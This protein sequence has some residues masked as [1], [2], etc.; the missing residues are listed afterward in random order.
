VRKSTLFLLHSVSH[1]LLVLF[2]CARLR[3]SGSLLL[4]KGTQAR[5]QSKG[6]TAAR[7][8]CH[9]FKLQM[10]R[11][12]KSKISS[13][14]GERAPPICMR[15]FNAC[16]IDFISARSTLSLLSLS[17]FTSGTRIILKTP[18]VRDFHKLLPFPKRGLQ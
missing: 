3:Q 9:F 1:S 13:S 7:F 17:C 10:C 4:L 18:D 11:C 14:F 16:V 6:F 5:V 12:G 2:I 15:I 8:L